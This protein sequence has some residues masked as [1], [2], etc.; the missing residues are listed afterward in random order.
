MRQ[1]AY[2]EPVRLVRR[3]FMRTFL[4]FM[5][6]SILP[7]ACI[8][9]AYSI[10]YI[11]KESSNIERSSLN[12]LSGLQETISMVFNDTS[13]VT[14]ILDSM[15]DIDVLHRMFSSPSPGQF[16]DYDEFSVC[17]QLANYMNAIVNSRTYIESIY[18]YYPNGKHAYL[19]NQMNIWND[20]TSLDPGWME[21][22]PVNRRYSISRR[23]IPGNNYDTLT[24][25]ERSSRGFYVA[26]NFDMLFFERLLTML[27]PVEGQSILLVDRLGDIL[28]AEFASSVSREDRALVAESISEAVEAASGMNVSRELSGFT[29]FFEYMDDF[30]I[31]CITAIADR[32]LFSHIYD[33]LRIMVVAIALCSIASVA[34][35]LG[36]SYSVTRRLKEIADLFDDARKGRDTHE[37][38]TRGNDIY[39]YIYD[40]LIRTFIRNE[41]TRI[42]LD[43][44]EIEAKYLELSA[45]QYQINPHFLYNSLQMI[46]FEVLRDVGRPCAANSMIEDLSRF[47]QYSLRNPEAS[48]ML[49]AEVDATKLYTNLMKSRMGDR[50]VFEWEIDDDAMDV[51]VPKLIIQPLVENSIQHGMAGDSSD[52]CISI[53]VSV[54]GKSVRIAVRDNGSGVSSSSLAELRGNL[55]SDSA[56]TESHIGLRN[57]VRRLR[58]RY[59][60]SFQCSVDSTEGRGFEVVFIIPDVENAEEGSDDEWN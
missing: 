36:E 6:M 18:V 40:H 50:L 27:N 44:K 42:A 43:E 59:G 9:L 8:F 5:M 16:E 10:Y 17:K 30:G 24:V 47:L 29:V 23:R 56:M 48:V 57:V 1:G 4:H 54:E 12:S 3:H 11:P 51:E 41:Y 7:M 31:L 33:L 19:T 35:S 26:V 58:L 15:N 55:V 28:A 13:K 39:Q 49:S 52:L 38:R 46:D 32:D 25:M 21:S 14:N 2:Y 53:T 22:I 20:E 34:I 37:G 60:Q 45:L